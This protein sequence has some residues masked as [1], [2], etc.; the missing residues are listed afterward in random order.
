MDD[1]S[2]P[3]E[4]EMN[5]QEYGGDDAPLSREQDQAIGDRTDGGYTGGTD[6]G[7]GAA[8]AAASGGA[9]AERQQ[10]Y[11]EGYEDTTANAGVNEFG[12]WS[13]TGVGTDLTDTMENPDPRSGMVKGG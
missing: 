4:S 6:F 7:T 2:R 3:G 12:T 8:E 13:D 9:T 5:I 11:N 1:R 10:A